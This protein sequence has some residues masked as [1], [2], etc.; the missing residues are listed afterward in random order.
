MSWGLDA[1]IL[2]FYS[3][4][5]CI[6]WG[7]EGLAAEKLHVV[8]PTLSGRGQSGT[9][10]GAGSPAPGWACCPGL[11]MESIPHPQINFPEVEKKRWIHVPRLW[12]CYGVGGFADRTWSFSALGVGAAETC[13]NSWKNYPGWNRNLLK[14]KMELPWVI[15]LPAVGDS[16]S[17][18]SRVCCSHAQHVLPMG[19]RLLEAKQG[20]RAFFPGKDKFLPFQQKKL[21]LTLGYNILRHLWGFFHLNYKY[22]N[23]VVAPCLF[24]ECFLWILQSCLEPLE[25][26][27]GVSL[28]KE[29]KLDS[30]CA[31]EWRVSWSFW[32][33]VLKKGQ[34]CSLF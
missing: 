33:W 23:R 15:F 30:T 29:P 4:Q 14:F 21:C 3:W 28:D 24:T 16:P 10:H 19:H 17:A 34:P 31:R 2:I 22:L 5:H 32:V 9:T 18:L 12:Y 25:G 1:F 6:A 26:L 27:N 11:S 20:G 7:G 8:H 13:N